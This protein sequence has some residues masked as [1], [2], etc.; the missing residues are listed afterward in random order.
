MGLLIFGIMFSIGLESEETASSAT[1]Q[2][3]T[4]TLQDVQ[5]EWSQLLEQLKGYS[6][7][8]RD[9]ALSRARRALDAMDAQ[10]EQLQA[11]A[12]RE[13]DQLGDTARERRRAALQS[14]QVQRQRLAEWYGGMKHSSAGA[15]NE[16]RRG[17]I[18]AYGRL[19]EAFGRAADAFGSE[20]GG[21]Q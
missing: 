4:P 6:S 12:D 13:W 2:D 17:F 3:D 8:Q 5:H 21:T 7:A 15:W 16:V 19:E 11:R 18:D 14:L 9:E 10:I 1:R 20:Q